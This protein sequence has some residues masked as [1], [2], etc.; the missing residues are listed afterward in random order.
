MN[1]ASIGRE[2]PVKAIESFPYKS[3]F[4]LLDFDLIL[5]D[6]AS[7]LLEYS[8]DSKYR[9]YPS[10]D[11]HDSVAIL[12]D[13]SR[14]KSEMVDLV[15]L[16]RTIVIFVPSPQKF[17]VDTGQRSY[18]GTGRNRSTTV[19]VSE[20]S[21][22]SFIPL[23][24]DFNTVEA[25]GSQMDFRGDD[26]F[27]E[28]W[29][30]N[31]DNLYYEAYFTHTIGRPFLFV[32][33]TDRV[34]GS[35]IRHERGNILLLPHLAYETSFTRKGDYN[36]ASKVFIDSLVSLVTALQK[37]SGDFSLPKWTLA[38]KLPEEDAL[39]QQMSAL[40][41]QMKNLR[42]SIDS[43]RSEISNLEKYKLL[44]SAKGNALHREVID[45]LKELGIDAKEGPA[46]RDD[47]LLTYESLVGVAEVK[48]TNK[49]AAEAHAAQ[50]E[51]WVSEYLTEQGVKPKGFLIVNA[52]HDIPPSSRSE[53]AFPNQM[54][55][56]STNRDHCLITTTQLLGLLLSTKSSPE[57]KPEIIRS[58]FAT[59]GVFR[60]FEDVAQ[61][62]HVDQAETDVVKQEVAQDE[63]GKP[64]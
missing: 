41:D 33:G 15:K 20:E 49:S 52:F 1:I 64:A 23:S 48:G 47:I 16:G 13:R 53:D 5:W 25:N 34:V 19:H 55:K 29:I 54:L 7:L 61:F 12:E 2:F 63:K 39:R 60:G 58:L 35:L 50:L 43:K 3:E 4:T 31:K 57:K 38:Y 44:L 6:P 22:R 51:K 17:Y 27:R 46:G 62:M 14:R 21:L 8:Y 18:S 40:Q 28:F 32:H 59:V 26:T 36:L 10:L 37:E 30:A 11:S 56:Y 24:G 42:S 45:V 9:G